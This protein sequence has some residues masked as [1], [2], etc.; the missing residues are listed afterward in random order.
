MTPSRSLKHLETVGREVPLTAANSSMFLTFD[1][2]TTLP[3]R[4]G[5][6]GCRSIPRVGMR[7][8]NGRTYLTYAKLCR[9]PTSDT[10]KD[11]SGFASGDEGIC[12]SRRCSPLSIPPQGPQFQARPK[13]ESKRDLLLPS[14]GGVQGRNARH[15]NPLGNLPFV[16]GTLHPDPHAGS[17]PEELAKAQ[18]NLR[19]NGLS[20]S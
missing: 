20:F 13:P 12:Q 16:I 2:E 8:H 1:C 6:H 15:V 11:R 4:A 14:L 9:R 19:A 5:D 10:S 18:R 17:V 7:I 3:L